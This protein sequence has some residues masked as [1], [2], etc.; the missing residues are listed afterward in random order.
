[1]ETSDVV[2][3][4]MVRVQAVD[5]QA[6]LTLDAVA[7]SSGRKGD[8]ITVRNPSTGRTFRGIVQDKGKVIVRP[9]PGD[10]F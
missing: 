9:S 4:A 5:G 10:E 7:E 3:G 1:M 6:L 2:R 8:Q